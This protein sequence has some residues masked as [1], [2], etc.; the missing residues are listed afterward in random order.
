LIRGLVIGALK[1]ALARGSHRSTSTNAR[2]AINLLAGKYAHRNAAPAN[3]EY[4]DSLSAR[5]FWKNHQEAFLDI[6][7]SADARPH[8]AIKQDIGNAPEI[9]YA[10]LVPRARDTRNLYY[11]NT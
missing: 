5:R 1:Q 9:D 3:W 7:P 4:S 2:A 10:P 8:E 11:L 6:P